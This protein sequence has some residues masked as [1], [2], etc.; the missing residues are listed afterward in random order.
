M[1]DEHAGF[2]IEGMRLDNSGFK[3]LDGG[4]NTGFTRNEWMAKACYNPRPARRGAERVSPQARLLGRAA[5]TRRTSASPTPTSHA[6]PDRRYR[7]SKD[8]QMDNHRTSIELSHKLR[9]SPDIDMTTTAYRH[10]FA[11]VWRKVNGIRGADLSDVLAHPETP[12]NA[13]YR[14][15]LT[16]EVDTQDASQAILVGPNNRKFVS[17]G[18]QTQVR[19]AGKTGPIQ[20]RVTYGV[21]AHYDE[22]ARLHTQD[23]FLMTS[24][25]LVSDG[26]VDRGHGRQQGADPRA[27]DVGGRRDD[28]SAPS[29]SR[30]ASASRPSTRRT[31]D[32]QSGLHD[33]ATY[34]EVIPGV[35]GYWALRR[36]FGVLA[37]VHKGFSPVPPEQA[38]HAAAEESVNYEGGFRFARRNVRARDHRLLQRLLEPH[39]HLYDL[40]RLLAGQPRQAS[41][42]PVARASPAPRSSARPR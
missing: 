14:G 8:N 11:R 36:D 37:G 16:G 31:R 30:P 6:T 17:Q 2:L 3:E 10:D 18:V 20:H 26:R 28:A 12:R 5:R 33:G 40:E 38:R 41:S 1:S 25:E 34:R 21:R 24:G 15:N 35:S 32:N 4:G 13:I 39:R 19:V 27:R 23:G 22:I 9:F 42:V 29:R 7:A